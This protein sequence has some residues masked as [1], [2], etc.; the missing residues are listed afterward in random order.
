MWKM[1]PQSSQQQEREKP[2]SVMEMMTSQSK[3]VTSDICRISK[4]I[5]S[6]LCQ[7][8]FSAF[9]RHFRD[10]HSSTWFGKGCRMAKQVQLCFSFSVPDSQAA[11]FRLLNKIP[12]V[13]TTFWVFHSQ[14]ESS[15]KSFSSYRF[16]NKQNNKAK[17]LNCLAFLWCSFV[18]RVS[19]HVAVLEIH[20]EMYSQWEFHLCG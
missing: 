19:I 1:L 9:S 3:I 11:L 5:F 2:G 7:Y 4:E 6:E 16:K 12:K 8:H 18:F 17:L 10:P 14:Q 13:V 15:V 20:T